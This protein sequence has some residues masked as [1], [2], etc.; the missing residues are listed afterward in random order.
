MAR[1][2]SITPNTARGGQLALWCRVRGT[3][4]TLL[5]GCCARC[6]SAE[7]RNFLFFG[8]LRRKVFERDGGACR[9]CA[10]PGTSEIRIHVHH[11][12][13]GVSRERL[14]ISLCPA[15]HA[16]VHHLRVLDRMLP[17]LAAE[18]WRELHP[19]APEQLFLG[20]EAMEGERSAAAAWL[21]EESRAS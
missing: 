3:P 6:H 18:L 12:K 5:R 19:G 10:Q 21:W 4:G 17:A 16:Q 14:S 1:I 8:G 7:R 9:V 2:L 15:H 13:P 20:F 11:R